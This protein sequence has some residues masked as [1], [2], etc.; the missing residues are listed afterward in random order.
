MK[1]KKFTFNNDH[2][3]FFIAHILLLLKYLGNGE[4]TKD[5]EKKTNNVEKWNINKKK[6]RKTSIDRLS[7]SLSSHK[8]QTFISRS[9]AHTRVFSPKSKRTAESL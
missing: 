1:L 3:L 9:K 5:K 7:L 4:D 8:R 6:V 2:N